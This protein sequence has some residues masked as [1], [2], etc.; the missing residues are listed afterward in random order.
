MQQ[1]FLSLLTLEQRRRIDQ[2]AVVQSIA[3]RWG[4]NTLQG[5]DNVDGKVP[6]VLQLLIAALVLAG[7]NKNFH[8]FI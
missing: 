6:L 3:V 8:G 1:V 5:V 4:V 7:K 2:N